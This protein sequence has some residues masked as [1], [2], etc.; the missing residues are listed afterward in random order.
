MV[1]L[2]YCLSE[3]A[4]GI[5]AFVLR[6]N[7]RTIAQ[8][9]WS[10]L[11]EAGTPGQDVLLQIE[12]LVCR[13]CACWGRRWLI[14]WNIRGVGSCSRRGGEGGDSSGAAVSCPSMTKW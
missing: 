1:L 4:G 7:V 9:F 12:N 11:Y 14:R 6:S 8:T 3:M 13:R 2:L 10:T 5:G